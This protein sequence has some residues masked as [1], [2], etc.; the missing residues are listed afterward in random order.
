MAAGSRLRCCARRPPSRSGPA[1]IGRSARPLP[2]RG[3]HRAPRRRRPAPTRARTTTIAFGPWCRRRRCSSSSGGR[4]R[5]HPAGRPELSPALRLSPATAR[6]LVD[7]QPVRRPQCGRPGLERGCAARRARQ[8]PRSA[9]PARRRQRVLG[10]GIGA[11][12]AVRRAL[13]PDRGRDRHQRPAPGP[14]HD[15]GGERREDAVRQQHGPRDAH[16]A[17]RHHRLRRLAGRAR[18]AGMPPWARPT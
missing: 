14:G 1:R 16:A 18:L 12:P 2:S 11:Q 15:R 4:G 9:F 8:R 13:L 10:A 5:R 17:D 3:T 6:R 7:V